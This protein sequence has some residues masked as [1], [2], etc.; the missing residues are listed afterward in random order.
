MQRGDHHDTHDTRKR[1]KNRGIK[2]NVH[3]STEEQ[4]AKEKAARKSV[5]EEHVHVLI[6]CYG[7]DYSRPEEPNMYIDRLDYPYL[8][9]DYLAEPDDPAVDDN[10]LR[11]ITNDEDLA[12]W[13]DREFE[14]WDIQE[15]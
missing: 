9:P 4:P 3:Q 7:I 11:E 2:L 14:W 10:H 15:L 1:A 13:A 6:G 12:A 8:A 5:S